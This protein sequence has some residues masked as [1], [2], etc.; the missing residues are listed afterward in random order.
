[1]LGRTGREHA[2][3]RSVLPVTRR[4]WCSCWILIDPSRSDSCLHAHFCA[5][6]SLHPDLNFSERSADTPELTCAS[7]VH[8]NKVVLLQEENKLQLQHLQPMLELSLQ[9]NQKI[10]AIL[11]QEVGRTRQQHAYGSLR[12]LSTRC[13]SV[14]RVLTY[15]SC[16]CLCICCTSADQELQRGHPEESRHDQCLNRCDDTPRR[17]CLL[18]S[19]ASI[20]LSF[21]C[22]P[23]TAV[24]CLSLIVHQ[25]HL[26]ALSHTSKH[27]K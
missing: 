17:L 13:P 8:S 3:A 5:L 9:A 25:A 23:T 4:C 18:D 6:V 11:K 1:M 12:Y 14:V 7:L 21:F 19:L 22:S 2:A 27:S 20:R 16:C 24:G 10:F 15:C 26:I